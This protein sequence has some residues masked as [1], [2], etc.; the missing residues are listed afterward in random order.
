MSTAMSFRSSRKSRERSDDDGNRFLIDERREHGEADGPPRREKDFLP[1]LFLLL[2]VV[3]RLPFTSRFLLNMDACQFALALDRFDITVHQPH[4]PGYFLYVLIGRLLNSFLT[5]ANGIFVSISVFSSGLTIA[6][7]YLLGKET[8]NRNVGIVAAL[9]ALSSPSLWF[10]GEVSL[11]YI[12]EAFFSTAFA[13]LCWRV[14]RGNEQYL[15]ASAA[16]LGI[17]G[18]IRQ[19]TPVFLF[20]LWIYS[21]RN[22]PPRK[23]FIALGMFLVTSLSWFFPMI[24]MT[25]GWDAYRSAFG[26]LWKFHTGGNSVFERGWSVFGVYSLTLVRYVLYGIG[27]GIFLLAAFLYSRIRGRLE[28]SPDKERALFFSLWCLPVVFF[29]LFVF[30]SIQNPGYSLI[31]LPSLLILVAVAV[32]RI[33]NVGRNRLAFPVR[34]IV[35]AFLL[36]TNSL[37]FLFSRSPVSYLW[38]REHDRDLGL[39]VEELK[40]YEPDR[41]AVFVN[42]YVYY[43]YRHVMYY[44]PDHISFNVDVRVASDGEIRKTFYGIHGKTRLA[45]GFPVPESVQ[46]FVVPLIRDDEKYRGVVRSKPAGITVRDL[47]SD[48]RI[49]SGPISRIREIFPEVQVR[50][51]PQRHGGIFEP[52]SRPV[53]PFSTWNHPKGRSFI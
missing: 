36:A 21:M 48:I 11:S 37:F 30:V 6:G 31:F 34:S 47:T 12:V 4:P 23:V 7:V 2:G 10:H 42:N 41:T 33:G 15:W 20:P 25:G 17:A 35:L 8:Y 53:S 38:I 29:Y 3:S 18:G 40:A 28:A 45:D 52:A 9:L 1:F 22:L 19:N 27:F 16:L 13:L 39:L 49:V 50:L 24:R 14:V 51:T 26:E 43:S 32:E 46:R 5:D 44:L